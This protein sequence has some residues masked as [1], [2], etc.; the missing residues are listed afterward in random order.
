VSQA[1][2]QTIA[3]ANGAIASAGTGAAQPGNDA[4]AGS[5]A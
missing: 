5:P 4:H 2:S 3:T 1:T